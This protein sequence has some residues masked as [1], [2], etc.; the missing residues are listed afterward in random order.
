MGAS[1]LWWEQVFLVALALWA[2][3]RPEARSEQMLEVERSVVASLVV[4]QLVV[5]SAQTLGV[6]RLVGGSVV[7]LLGEEPLVAHS[8][9]RL[10]VERSVEASVSVL[11]V[12]EP[13][14]AHWE[15]A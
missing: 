4:E 15:Q 7:M 13:P 3:G 11:S 10:E 5:H 1:L 14:V 9:Q 2:V 6:E 8:A 12:V